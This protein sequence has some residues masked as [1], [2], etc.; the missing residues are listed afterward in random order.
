[1]YISGE[2]GFHVHDPGENMPWLLNN[3]DS[4]L[5]FYWEKRQLSCFICLPVL[6]LK[7]M[8]IFYDFSLASE[9][10]YAS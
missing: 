1:M 10:K 4:L 2:F 9:L 7:K 6:F 3:L 8:F 5:V